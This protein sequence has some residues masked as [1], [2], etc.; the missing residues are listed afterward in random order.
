M[1][2]GL[3]EALAQF[4]R[5]EAIPYF[6]RALE[7]DFYRSAAEEA[8][9]KMGVAACGALA[10]SA[11]TPQPDFFMET[12]SSL[13]RRRSAV[14]LMFKVGMPAECWRILR[15]L[16]HD[17]DAELFVNVS[18]LGVK[19]GSK[20]ERAVIA[21]GILRLSSSA[22]WYLQEDIEEILV[23]LGSDATADIDEEISR[24]MR[25][26][27]DVRAGDIRLRSLIRVRR[28]LK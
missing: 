27:E 10:S 21:H 2:L 13:Q 7:D 22:P 17:P 11:V 9:L 1:L 26:P 6:E 24:R 12:P 20:D 19:I 15:E 16:L 28:R 5:P 18:K 3:I 8:F 14:R 23:Q 25:Q 4:G